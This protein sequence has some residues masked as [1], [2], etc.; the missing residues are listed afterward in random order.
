MMRKRQLGLLTFGG[1]E[2]TTI[3]WTRMSGADGALMGE[4]ILSDG[5]A[6][7]ADGRPRGSRHGA[8][9]VHSVRCSLGKPRPWNLRS[10]PRIASRSEA[11]P[12]PQG[13]ERLK[14][15]RTQRT[16]RSVQINALKRP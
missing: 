8:A 7:R 13:A 3:A 14:E 6:L 5:D 4:A 2:E 11:R 16:G 10:G 12:S 1:G 15:R 9:L